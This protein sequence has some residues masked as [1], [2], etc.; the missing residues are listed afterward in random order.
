MVDISIVIVNYNVKDVLDNCIASIYK[1][2][3]KNHNIEIFLVDNKSVDGSVK[4]IREKYPEVKVIANTANV[5]FSKANNQAL[6]QISGKYVLI[7]NPDT[8]LEEGTFEKLLNFYESRKD[9]GVVSSKLIMANG[10][11]DGACRRSFPTL[12]VALPRIFG[13]SKLFPKSKFFGK[14]NLTY[15]DEN[16]ISEVD[17]VCGAFM[18]MSKRI[19]DEVGIFDEEYF[20]YGEDLDLCYRIKNKGYKNYYYPEVKTIHLKG[21]STRKTGLSYVNNFYGAMS[22]FVRK[23]LKGASFVVSILLR[24]GIFLRSLVSYL[25]RMLKYVV[26]PVL[27]IMIILTSF[28]IAVQYRF[29]IFPTRQYFFI[30]FVYILIWLFLLVIFGAYTK[31]GRFSVLRSFNAVLTGFFINSSITY[32]FK[33][34]AYSREVIL[35]ATVFSVAGMS[36]WR[37]AVNIYRFFISKNILLNKINLLVVGEKELTQEMEDRL[38]AKYNVYY[39]NKISEKNEIEDLEEIIKIKDINEIILADDKFSNQE[40][41]KLMGRLKN[42]NVNFKILPTETELILSKIHSNIENLSLIEI[43]YNINNKLNIFLKRTFD[44]VLSFFCLITIYPL[45]LLVKIFRK[46]ELSK[47]T[48]KLLNLPSVLTGKYSMV[49]IPMWYE[50]ERLVHLGKKGLTGLIQLNWYDGI[51]ENE[52][53]NFNLFYA[54]NQSIL[55]DIEI[56]LKTVISY[57]KK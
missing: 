52:M 21:E 32:F 1:S 8:V 54:K 40:I 43:E 50:E 48:S 12:S 18:F 28:I 22:V 33:Q 31:K 9:T 27:D 46:K 11:I 23:N 57:F 19:L 5:G 45:V 17:S 7:L 4:H 15:L 47:H 53:I 29:K 37:I 44:I 16:K 2:N 36:L 26:S 38:I 25:K 13:L 20:M 49:G 55:L 42:R 30:I 14:Y 35:M 51:T 41:L 24:F 39:F 10:K 3:S 6:R 34:Y 56:L